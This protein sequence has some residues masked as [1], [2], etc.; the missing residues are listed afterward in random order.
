MVL[1]MLG[2]V[3]YSVYLNEHALSICDTLGTVL[4][5]GHRDEKA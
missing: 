4:G 5:T 3:A 2:N 1:Q